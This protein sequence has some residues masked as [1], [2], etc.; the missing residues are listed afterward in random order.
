MLR[1]CRLTISIP[2]T[3]FLVAGKDVI[4]SDS[5]PIHI[6]DGT[7]EAV[8]SF[9]YLGSIVE[10]H[11]GVNAEPTARVSRAAAVFGALRRSVFC[12]SSLSILTKSIMYQAVV[13]DILLYAVETWPIKQR[14]LHSLEV[15]HHRCLRNILGFNRLHSTSVMRKFGAGWV[16]LFH[17][18]ML[19]LVVGFV[20]WV[21]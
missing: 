19:S 9:R 3:K 5:D 6:G 16:C 21:I 11:G 2:K 14:D 10:C 17:W 1:A 7:I 8:S 18:Q 13:I 12:D 20:G 15:F 4:Q